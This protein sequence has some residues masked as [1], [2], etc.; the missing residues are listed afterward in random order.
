[1]KVFMKV[2][3]KHYTDTKLASEGSF[4]LGAC[5]KK[6]SNFFFAPPKKDNGLS[7]SLERNLNLF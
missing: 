3:R 4:N 1:M 5:F 2:Y 7:Y 6:W